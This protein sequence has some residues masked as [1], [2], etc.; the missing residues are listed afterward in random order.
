MKRR[1]VKVWKQRWAVAVA[2]LCILQG[3]AAADKGFC[4]SVPLDGAGT[5][6]IVIGGRNV[7]KAVSLAVVMDASG[8]RSIVLERH[9]GA[10]S[11]RLATG[12]GE[13]RAFVYVF[14]G[15]FWFTGNDELRITVSPAGTG[16]VEVM[17]E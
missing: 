17:C 2:A 14:D 1:C 12:E 6:R 11:Y 8:E 16:I 7:W 4:L 13:G 9:S 3:A 15:P 5:A 10:L